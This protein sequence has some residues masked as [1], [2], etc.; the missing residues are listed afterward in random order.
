MGNPHFLPR[1]DLFSVFVHG[2][3]YKRWK[4]ITTKEYTRGVV[5]GWTMTGHDN[6]RAI[7]QKCALIALLVVV[8]VTAEGKKLF[9]SHRCD[10]NKRFN[11]IREHFCEQYRGV[12]CEE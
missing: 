8:Q 3:K 9:D 2:Q 11:K 5:H 10:L 6:S 1:F 12:V 7:L 4:G